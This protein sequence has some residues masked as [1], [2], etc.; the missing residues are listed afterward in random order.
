[1]LADPN[2]FRELH[3]RGYFYDEKFLTYMKNLGEY[4]FLP[5]YVEMVKYP[6]GLWNLKS[7]LSEGFIET[8]KDGASLEKFLDFTKKRNAEL[9]KKQNYK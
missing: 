1:M 4:M 5:Q 2:Y 7:L 9:W 6:E 8:I 3:K